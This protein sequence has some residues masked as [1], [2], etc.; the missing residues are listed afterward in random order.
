MIFSER[1]DS[2][3]I[4]FQESDSDELKR[5]VEAQFSAIKATVRLLSEVKNEK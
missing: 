1:Y 4:E 2:F 3:E 5:Y